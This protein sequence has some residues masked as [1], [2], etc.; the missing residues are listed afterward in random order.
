[1]PSTRAVA[2]LAPRQLA[3]PA[4]PPA[5]ARQVV[6]VE[7]HDDAVGG[8]VDVGLEVAVAELD[9]AAGTPAWCSPGPRWPRRGGRTRSARASRGTGGAAER[10]RLHGR[11]VWSSHELTHDGARRSRSPASASP[12][13]SRPSSRR[14]YDGADDRPG[15]RVRRRRRRPRRGRG[16]AALAGRAAAALE[17]GRGA[18]QRRPRCSPS[19]ARSSPAIIAERGGQADQDRPGRGRAGGRHVPVRRRRGPHAGRRGGR[20][21]TPSPAA[22]ARSASRCGCRSASSAR[23][24]PFNFPLNL[25]AHKLAP[26]IA[27]GCPVV[28]KPASQTPFSAIAPRRA[29]DRRVRPACRVAARRDR[30]R[31]ARSATRSSTTPTSR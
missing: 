15:A 17:A 27:A 29:A 10:V 25:V 6:V 20:R 24:R 16:E 7:R 2:H 3:D 5:R 30:R 14:P 9:R 18:R 23:S 21:S 12:A 26:A 31:L 19:G 4:R 11:E 13:P 1:M 8:D 22:R 28:L